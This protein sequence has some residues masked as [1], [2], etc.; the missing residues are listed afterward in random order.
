LKADSARYVV[1][2][3]CGAIEALAQLFALVRR[4]ENRPNEHGLVT[5]TVLTPHL[6]VILR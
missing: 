6:C 2:G 4:I 1:S 5:A 3:P